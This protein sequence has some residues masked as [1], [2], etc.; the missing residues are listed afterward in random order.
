MT[1]KTETIERNE[2]F[3]LAY[4]FVTETSEHIFLTGKAGTGKTTFL[5]FLK[6]NCTKNTVVAA[7]TGVAA[8]NAG[9]VTLH[10]LFQLPFHPFIPT[11]AGKEDLLGKMKFNKQRL[12]LLRKTELLIID[13]IS[14]VRC[15]VIDAIDTLLRSVRRNHHTPFGGI[16][17]LCIGDLHQLP[18]VA[19][20]HEWNI[21]QEYYPSPFF[22]DSH[23]IK[24]QQPVLIELD[25]I[26][27]QKEESFV[28]LLNKVRTNNMGAEDFE[29]LHQRFIPGFRPGEDEKYI[30][31][32]SHNKQADLINNS[33]IQKL[34]TPHFIFQAEI[35]NEFPENQYPAD[36]SLMLKEGAQVMF[37]KNDVVEKRYF[38]GKIGVVCRLDNDKISVN[39]GGE[40]IEVYKET[41][42]N[43][44]Y[45]LNRTDGKLQQDVIGTFTQYPLRLAWGITIHKSQGLTFDNLMIDA[46]AAF[47]SGQ[48]YVALSRCTSLRGIVLLSK[49]PPSAILS[50]ENVSKGQQSLTHKGSLAERFT[51]AREVYTQQLLEE[52]FSF[53]EATE[54]LQQ[55][56]YHIDAQK[57]K[58]NAGSTDWINNLFGAFEKEKLNGEKF[59]R[60]IYTLLKEEPVIEN[61]AGLQ[62]RIALAAAHFIPKFAAYSDALKKHP[63][64]TEHKETADV[65][66]EHLN[67]AAQ[68]LSAT[69]YY[70]QY[71]KSPFSVTAF[72]QHKLNLTQPRTGISCYA[73][74]RSSGTTDSPNPE[75]YESI[76]RWRDIQCEEEGLPVFLVV[77]H[78]GM[79]DICTYLP[80]T[81]RDLMLISGFG[82]VKVDKYGEEITTIVND[83]CELHNIESSIAQ[84]KASP[85]K[86]RKPKADKVDTKDSTYTLFKAGKSISEIAKER[87][88]ALSTIEGHLAALIEKGIVEVGELLTP[89]RFNEISAVFKNRG[90][91]TLSEMKSE[92]PWASF[93]EMRMAEAALKVLNHEGAK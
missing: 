37:I 3:D 10:S 75:L 9:G 57:E 81:K 79:K 19:Q 60:Q 80:K 84:K 89:E 26:Y 27:R 18:P 38:N 1:T 92:M 85:K 51:G 91:K 56:K 17:L 11:S 21:L 39:C 6:E 45:T 93:G 59:I 54:S 16:Q 28:E 8:I 67:S 88:F 66:N 35:E 43:S 32:T 74:G 23:A 73:R 83:Y 30:T 24:E 65:I 90:D 20:N 76:K 41:W 5:K 14:M 22:F 4:R 86:E 47:S 44:R 36:A 55:L 72:L 64:I 40:K 70:L 58:L 50:N 29:M 49:I 13:E 2:I 15:D 12:Q 52:I 53:S 68:A 87:G 77:T 34:H 78:A 61:N 71:C 82:K 46:A 25:K 31:L 42:E 48:V 62:N 7:P 33:E 63:L 69:D